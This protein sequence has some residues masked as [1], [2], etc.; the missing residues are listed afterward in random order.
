M[1]NKFVVQNGVVVSGVVTLVCKGNSFAKVSLDNLV[2]IKNPIIFG[3]I[4]L[5]DQGLVELP[6]MSN[7]IMYGSF[8]CQNNNLKSLKGIPR[9]VNGCVDCSNNNIKSLRHM[10]KHIGDGF[11]FSH[12]EVDSLH[13]LSEDIQGD[14]DASYNNLVDLSYCVSECHGRFNCSYKK[15]VSL[16]G[17]LNIVWSSMD[18]SYN[19]LPNL[20]DMPSTIYGDLVCLGNEFPDNFNVYKDVPGEVMGNII[21]D[22]KKVINENISTNKF[23]ALIGKIKS[24]LMQRSK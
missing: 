3:D 11:N 22:K 10:P 16:N 14:I 8:L 15:L 23:N 13:Y 20:E 1:R 21:C 18:C 9:Q 4:D 12:N 5:S 7:A 6:Q 24:N 17:C 2:N 19:Y